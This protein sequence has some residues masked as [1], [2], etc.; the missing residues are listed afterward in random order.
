MDD[1][2]FDCIFAHLDAIR[3]SL[4]FRSSVYTS[5]VIVGVFAEMLFLCIDHRD[6]FNKWRFAKIY[7]KIPFPERPGRGKLVLEWVSV[8]LVVWGLVGEL[9]TSNRIEDLDTLIRA[10]GGY[11]TALLQQEAGDAAAN[12]ERAEVAADV[13]EAKANELIRDLSDRV[14]LH[15]N[16]LYADIQ[17]RFGPSPEAIKASHGTA[18][19]LGIGVNSYRGDREAY[20]LCMQLSRIIESAINAP[21][22]TPC[23]AREPLPDTPLVVGIEVS[24]GNASNVKDLADFLSKS[25]LPSVFI[26]TIRP[27]RGLSIFV[28]KPKGLTPAPIIPKRKRY[29]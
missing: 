21:A 22:R 28:G 5:L 4:D 23:E 19:G 20:K 6:E 17:K 2:I 13:A 27:D 9:R 16:I 8:G 29:P 24:G 11:R 15:P 26:G 7:F 10:V 12:A 3:A 25:G 18:A 14:I 1:S